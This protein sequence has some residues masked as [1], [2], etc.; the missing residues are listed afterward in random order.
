MALGVGFGAGGFSYKRT[1]RKKTNSTT[2]R[3]APQE[4]LI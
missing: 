3:F 2:C 4:I 1:G